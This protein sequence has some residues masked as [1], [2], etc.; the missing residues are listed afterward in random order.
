MQKVNFRISKSK[1]NEWK[2]FCKKQGITLTSLIINSVEKRT[3]DSERRK[4]M[5]FIEKQVNLFAKVE[6]NINQLAK[7][8]NSQKFMTQQQA[9]EFE[10]YLRE[11]KKL[12]EEQNEILRK[13]YHFIANDSENFKFSE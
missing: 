6:N 8:V 9:G 1:K 7:Y 10:V 13:T 12:K 5:E 3:W 4:A 2:R 11:V